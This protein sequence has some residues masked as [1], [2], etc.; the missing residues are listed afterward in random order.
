[1]MRQRVSFDLAAFLLPIAR[2]AGDAIMSI[3]SSGQSGVR[4][5]A[6]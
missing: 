5:K 2:Q 6:D 4:E 1:M 3:Y